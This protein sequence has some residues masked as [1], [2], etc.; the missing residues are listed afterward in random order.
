MRSPS[1]ARC[2]PSVRVSWPKWYRTRRLA[3]GKITESVRGSRAG[4]RRPASTA[5]G[6]LDRRREGRDGAEADEDDPGEVPLNHRE[7]GAAPQ[8][9]P[10]RS[11]DD[12]PR[13][14]AEEAERREHQS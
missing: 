11:R 9:L 14:V 7:A 13:A 6:L 3:N 5:S 2:E 4:V 1:R 10:E 12:R 8:A